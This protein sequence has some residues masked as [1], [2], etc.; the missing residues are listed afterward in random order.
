MVVVASL[1]YA[2]VE[3]V[4]DVV[5]VPVGGRL[6]L[7]VTLPFDLLISPTDGADR[8]DIINVASG[9]FLAAVMAVL[10]WHPRTDA[11]VIR[12]SG[13]R[14][15]GFGRLLR[16]FDPTITAIKAVLRDFPSAL[17]AKHTNQPHFSA[18]PIGKQR[19]KI[20]A[21]TRRSAAQPRQ[22]SLR[23]GYSCP[24]RSCHSSFG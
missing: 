15:R 17:S 4:R 13:H 5:P 12:N 7:A 3:L 14:F 24:H 11:V 2:L 20:R 22:R 9:K 19:A 21:A 23:R 18:A 8:A 16:V 6:V 10:F 1:K